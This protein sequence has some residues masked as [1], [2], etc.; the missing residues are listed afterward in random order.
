MKNQSINQ[1]QVFTHILASTFSTPSS[2]FLFTMSSSEFVESN[3]ARSQVPCDHLLAVTSGHFAVVGTKV[4]ELPPL[5]IE[6]S[7]RLARLNV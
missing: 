2:Y 3:L 6:R 7:N 1:T 4:V 5:S